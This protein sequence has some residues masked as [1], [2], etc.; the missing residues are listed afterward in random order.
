M[1]QTGPKALF[2]LQQG[3]R[4]FH[5]TTFFYNGPDNGGECMITAC[6]SA[7]SNSGKFLLKDRMF[8]R[9]YAIYTILGGCESAPGL[10]K[11]P[12]WRN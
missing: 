1:R 11:K 6:V 4:L 9:H 8:S 12:E 5:F 2:L 7:P 3:L 10:R